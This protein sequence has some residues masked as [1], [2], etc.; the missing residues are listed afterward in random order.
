MAF[1]INIEQITSPN[2]LYWKLRYRIK[3]T[4]S[5]LTTNLNPAL[6]TG[7][8]DTSVTSVTISPQYDNTVYEYQLITRCGN[9][10][11]NSSIYTRIN[12]GCPTLLSQS[13]ITTDTSISLNF[14]LNTPAPISSHIDNIVVV[15]KQGSTLIN[16]QTLT[17]INS[18]NPVSFSNLTENTTYTIEYTITFTSDDNPV[19]LYSDGITSNTNKCTLSVTTEAAPTCPDIVITSVTQS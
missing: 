3:G 2:I 6:P 16:T 1:T 13:V 14:P 10:D 9:N 4:N 17:S 18:T 15:L 7:G 5:W 8:Y 11:V 12:R 19:S